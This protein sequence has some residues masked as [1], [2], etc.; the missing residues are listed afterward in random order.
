MKEGEREGRRKG[1]REEIARPEMQRKKKNEKSNQ[2][3]IW[4]VSETRWGIIL[5]ELKSQSFF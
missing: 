1:R 5:C 3:I 4:L 2:L